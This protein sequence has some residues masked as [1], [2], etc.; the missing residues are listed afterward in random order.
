MARKNL[1]IYL[2]TGNLP[3]LNSY[4]R[5]EFQE[6]KSVSKH[7]IKTQEMGNEIETGIIRVLKE[8]R[9]D[10]P[11]WIK[12]V[13][14]LSKKKAITV[15]HRTFVKCVILLRVRVGTHSRVF[16]LTFGNGDLL[17]N[18]EYIVSDFGLKISKSLLTVDQIS[19]IDSTSIDRK[20]FNTRKQSSTFLM[21]EKLNDYGTHSIVRKIHGS[22][23]GPHGTFTKTFFLG[24]SGGLQ[25]KGELDLLTELGPLLSNFGKLYEDYSD[26]DKKFTLTDNLTPVTRKN[27]KIELDEILGQKILDIINSPKFDKRSTSTF[28]ISPQ[29]IFD[30]DDFNGFFIT[31]LGYKSSQTT[32][33]FEIDEIDYLQR[34]NRQ[35][36]AQNRN[37]LGI[38]TKL[39]TD[40]ILKKNVESTELEKIC[41][42]YKAINFEAQHKENYY[43]LLSGKWY[44][45][46]KDFYIQIKE[47]VN[48]IPVLDSPNSLKFIKFDKTLHKKKGKF[49]E[50]K[51]NEDLAQKAN[52]LMLDRED[53]R[54]SLEKKKEYGIKTSSSIELCDLFH[55][56]SQK[57][58]FIHVKRHTGGAAGTSHLLS[59]ALVSAQTFNNDK[60][61]VVKFINKQI[62]KVNGNSPNFSILPF[63][64]RGQK[65]QVV[66]AI[67]DENFRVNTENSK[68]LSLL[69]MISLRE[70]MLILKSLGYEY[71]L[72][73]I[74][75]DKL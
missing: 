69:E 26:Q 62:K 74:P 52:M 12:H 45:L 11:E 50:G 27:E 37:I 55:H 29:E 1:N 33:S 10:Q 39:K 31:G 13:N 46:N 51:Y 24:G 75:S 34:F 21:A 16:A 67:I 17:L 32:T 14:E 56:T 22:F 66:L 8:I 35:L 73:F 49:S 30:I 54:I 47:D 19:S 23:K 42:V 64:D 48:S 20:I 58:Q 43:I 4:L 7:L 41:S 60:D 38:L 36:K 63:K 59:Q 5:E 9:D 6:E 72:N 71:Y 65:K 53:Y 15:P 3:G 70:N 61:E 44:E 57:V 68:M 2:L 40:E 25:F 28:K 18:P